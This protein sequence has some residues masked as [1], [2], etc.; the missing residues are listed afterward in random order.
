M[1][2]FIKNRFLDIFLRTLSM[3]QA[4]LILFPLAAT[5]WYIAFLVNMLS[6]IIL[7]SRRVCLS[8]FVLSFVFWEVES[9]YILYL[10]V[11]MLIS[12]QG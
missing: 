1:K 2:Q 5:D 7:V 11:K 4:Y 9:R 10:G 3:L 12:K 6:T 8:F